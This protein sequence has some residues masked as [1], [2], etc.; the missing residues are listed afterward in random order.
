VTQWMGF[1][2]KGQ[3]TAEEQAKALPK[4]DKIARKLGLAPS[5]WY[6]R[7]LNSIWKFFYEYKNRS[8]RPIGYK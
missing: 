5:P 3:I 1:V 8:R 4:L 7:L 6:Y 2:K